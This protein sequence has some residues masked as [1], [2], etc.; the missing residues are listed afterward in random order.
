MGDSFF[1]VSDIVCNTSQSFLSASPA[2]RHFSLSTWSHS[3]SRS[4]GIALRGSPLQVPS[5]QVSPGN[6]LTLCMVC[7]F[8]RS[9]PDCR[10]ATK[11]GRLD[12]RRANCLPLS[13]ATVLHHLE[14]YN[15]EYSYTTFPVNHTEVINSAVGKKQTT[16]KLTNE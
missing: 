9:Y 1:G 11:R 3:L 13:E 2:L 12:L 6:I 14:N 15:S 7:S 4:E 8:N 5:I 10:H 16:Q